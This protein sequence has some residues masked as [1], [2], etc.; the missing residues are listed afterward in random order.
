MELKKC[1]SGHYYDASVYSECPTCQNANRE[2]MRTM[3][4]DGGTEKFGATM[5]LGGMGDSGATMPVGGGMGDSG[6]TMP[7]GCSGTMDFRTAPVSGG[8]TMPFTNA[9]PAGRDEGKT[10]AVVSKQMGID[11]VVGWLVSINGPEKGRDYQ[12]HSDNNFIG[13]GEKNDIC[14]RGDETI[15]RER[16]AII[17]YDVRA[18]KFYFAPGEGRSISRVNDEPVLGMREIQAYDEIE[19]GCTKLVFIPLCGERF[20]W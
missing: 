14:V 12:I 11:P 20:E 8:S 13:R 9:S 7:V 5:P 17:A 18:K 6:A 4:F 2:G 15:S 16:H 1:K 19:I 3:G 10:I